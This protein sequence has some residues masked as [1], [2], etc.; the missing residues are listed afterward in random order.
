MVG[1]RNCSI[2]DSAARRERIR[3]SDGGISELYGSA[4]NMSAGAYQVFRWW[5]IGTIKCIH[6]L[7]KLSVSGFP[8]VG[9]RNMTPLA[10]ATAKERIRFSDG[11]ISEQY[12]Q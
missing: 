11:G 1:Y 6:E 4:G 2:A 12:P 9:Y 3:F 5:D 7:L 10:S 8:M